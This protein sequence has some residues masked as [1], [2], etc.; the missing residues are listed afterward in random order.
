MFSLALTDRTHCP[1]CATA[2]GPP[3]YR[4][5]LDADPMRTYLRDFYDGRL[6]VD[7]LEGDFTLVDCSGCGLLYQVRVPAQLSVAA[8]YE[9]VVDAERDD[10]EHRRGATLRGG[11]PRDPAPSRIH[12]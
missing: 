3:V 8:F 6:D 10:V 2:G 5:A 4:A 9:Q 11:A 1:V 7:S 12:H